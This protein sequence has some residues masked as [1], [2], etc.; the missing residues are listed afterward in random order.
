MERAVVDAPGQLEV[1]EFLESLHNNGLFFEALDADTARRVAESLKR[2]SIS[3]QR[4][5]SNSLDDLE[6]DYVRRLGD[7]ISWLDE[8]LASL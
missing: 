2:S 7:L 1:R 3:L 8:L 5:F 4:Q 6:L